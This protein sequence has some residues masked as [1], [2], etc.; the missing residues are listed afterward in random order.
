MKYSEANTV[1][2]RMYCALKVIE[3]NPHIAAWLRLND[4]MALKQVRDAAEE[5]ANRFGY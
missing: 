3:L 1:E 4:P 5:A 2:A